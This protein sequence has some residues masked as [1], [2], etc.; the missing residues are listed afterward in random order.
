MEKG[1]LKKF[2]KIH[3]KTPVAC[4]FIKKET[5]T[6]VFSSE[7]WENFKNIFFYRTP[8]DD[9]F[10]IFCLSRIGLRKNIQENCKC[11]PGFIQFFHLFKDKWNSMF[12]AI[13]YFCSMLAR[14]LLF[15]CNV[16]K[17]C[18]MLPRHLQQP[19][20][21]KKLTGREQKSQKS[22]VAQ[23]TIHWLTQYCS[24]SLG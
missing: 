1:I 12:R 17:L 3:R 18:A 14:D 2:I 10:W 7:F 16:W 8:Q 6:Q 11:N 19:I 20:I 15:F 13:L 23:T 4:N 24:K 9:Y 21:I 22:N 5:P